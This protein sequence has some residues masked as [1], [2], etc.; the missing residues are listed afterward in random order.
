MTEVNWKKEI[1]RWQQSKLSMAEFC[2]SENLSYWSFRQGRKNIEKTDIAGTKGLVKLNLLD[3]PS[4]ETGKSSIEIY[5]GETRI[6][7]PPDFNES[8]LQRLITALRKVS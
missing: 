5:L 4:G 6:V 3:L 8:H 2:R 1:E 7:V